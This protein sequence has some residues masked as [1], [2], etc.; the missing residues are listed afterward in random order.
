MAQKFWAKTLIGS[1]PLIRTWCLKSL[2]FVFLLFRLSTQ[3]KLDGCELRPINLKTSKAARGQ[4]HGCQASH[5]HSALPN[6]SRRH[7]QS[8]SPPDRGWAFGSHVGILTKFIANTCK[9]IIHHTSKENKE[10]RKTGDIT[11]NWQSLANDQGNARFFCL[12]MWSK[13]FSRCSV[14]VGLTCLLF[15]VHL[16][17]FGTMVGEGTKCW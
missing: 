2:S 17:M 6:P 16:Q 5:E 12:S 4:F 15:G 11:L 8:H 14:L 10:V 1:K 3:K 9:S 7:D 13:C